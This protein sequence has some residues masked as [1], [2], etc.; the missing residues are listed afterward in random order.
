MYKA[1]VLDRSYLAAQN[2]NSFFKACPAFFS[3]LMPPKLLEE[4]G[5]CVMTL[6]KR[7]PF[8]GDIE[9]ARCCTSYPTDAT[10]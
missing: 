3:G 9:F 1:N 6:C 10:F 8:R 4:D 5:Q 2:V 7:V